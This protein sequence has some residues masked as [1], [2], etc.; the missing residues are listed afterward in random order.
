MTTSSFQLENAALDFVAGLQIR[1]TSGTLKSAD[2]FASRNLFPGKWEP[3]AYRLQ[4]TPTALLLQLDRPDNIRHFRVDLHHDGDVA[5]NFVLSH[6]PHHTD[7]DLRRTL[8]TKTA[9]FAGCARNCGARLPETLQKIAELGQLF[10]SYRVLVF[11]NDSTDDTLA[12]L[13]DFATRLPIR[14]LSEKG[15]DRVMPQRTARLAYAR[16]QL[17]DTAL[18]SDPEDYLVMC[19]MDGILDRHTPETASF[20]RA[21]ENASAWDAVFPVNKGPYYDIWALRHPVVF[22]HDYHRRGV[23]LDAAFGQDL[24]VHFAASHMQVDLRAMKGL[25][26][27]DSAFGGMGI[28]RTQSLNGARYIGME[29]GQEVC[30]HVAFH[31]TMASRGGRLYIHPGFQVNTHG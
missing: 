7:E 15:L 14:I 26:R 2:V 5:P 30:E 22:P 28:Y 4:S 19:D 12:V 18:A 24:A 10:A 23:E 21:F 1:T 13:E 29:N 16:N 6:L 17:M 25:L 9:L 3:L 8:Q 31:Q 27:V 20:L 11:E